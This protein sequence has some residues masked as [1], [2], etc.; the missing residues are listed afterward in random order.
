VAIDPDADVITA[1]EVGAANTG[2]AAR[3]AALLRYLL[4]AAPVVAEDLAAGTWS[5]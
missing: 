4:V 5:R 2:N 1:A 3:T